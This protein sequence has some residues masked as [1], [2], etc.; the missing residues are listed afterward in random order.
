MPLENYSIEQLEKELEK[1][2]HEK[3]KKPEMLI[4]LDFSFLVKVCQ[5]Y[6]DNTHE[7][8]YEE[9]LQH[10]IF[11]EAMKACYG[12]DIFNWINEKI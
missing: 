6:I 2:K 11:E 3:N 9:D 7:N 5:E 4:N 10:Y 8:Y 1:R 12:K